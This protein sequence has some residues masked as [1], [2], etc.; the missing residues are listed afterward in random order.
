MAHFAELDNNNIVLQILV[1][2]N[3][4]I[5]NSEGIED[6]Q[7]GID[8]F[9]EHLNSSNTFIQTSY[10]GTFR[11]NFASIGGTYDYEHGAFISEKDFDSWELDE[12]TF[13]YKP[14]IEE[15]SNE[16]IPTYSNGRPQ[17]YHKWDE[18]TIGW[19]HIPNKDLPLNSDELP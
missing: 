7:L 1:I 15:P 4:E 14:P 11:F 19:A 6:E 9:T 10:R 17:Y 2:D 18:E 8:F 12:T 5:L 16:D 13:T 3:Q